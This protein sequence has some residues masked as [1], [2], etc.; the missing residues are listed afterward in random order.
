MWCCVAYCG[1][2]IAVYGWSRVAVSLSDWLSSE[3]QRHSS[4]AYSGISSNYWVNVPQL[5]EPVRSL[6]CLQK[7]V[8]PILFLLRP[9]KRSFSPSP[10]QPRGLSPYPC[11]YFSS[12]T[13]SL[14]AGHPLWLGRSNNI[15]QALQ[16]MKLLI[17]QFSLLS[18]LLSSLKYFSRIPPHSVF[19]PPSII[20]RGPR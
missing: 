9:F 4:E 12:F 20:N 14:H 8:S 15:Q 16:V 19:F 1:G 18:P 11:M 7:P 3:E 5:T 6:P 2:Q 17:I 10:P 13:C